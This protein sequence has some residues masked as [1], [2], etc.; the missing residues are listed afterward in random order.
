MQP[1][2]TAQLYPTTPHTQTA[3]WFIFQDDNILLKETANG[4]LIPTTNDLSTL[5]DLIIQKHYLGLYGS[6]PCFTASLPV[7]ETLPLLSGL[8]FHPVRHAYLQLNQNES[9][10]H[11]ITRAKQILYWDDTTQFCGQC[12][13]KTESCENERAKQCLSCQRL[14]FPPISPVMLVLI[15][16]GEEILLARSAHFMPG[17]YSILAGFVEPGET[18][19]QTVAREVKEEVNIDIK[20]IRYFSSQPWPFSSNLMLGFMAEYDQGTIQIDPKEIEDA[21]W[22]K[23]SAL[24][25]LPA[26]FSLSRQ[27]IEHWLN[28]FSI[29]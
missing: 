9:L 16:R 14:I 7:Q 18:L 29:K 12:G 3:L 22:F 6:D 2:F 25:P 17:I 20:N 4:L 26:P 27:M 19:E 23:S 15:A 1:S 5:Q 11:L 28:Q 24:P 8:A 13:R 21:Q 10:C